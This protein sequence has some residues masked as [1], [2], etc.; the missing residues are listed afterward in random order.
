MLV[1]KKTEK[2]GHLSQ[3]GS[4]DF[5]IGVERPSHGVKKASFADAITDND[6]RA[7]G[8]NEYMIATF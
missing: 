3:I 7:S 5:L 2:S 4:W 8:E 6:L 1:L